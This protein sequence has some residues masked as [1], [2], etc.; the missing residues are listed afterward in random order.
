MLVLAST[1]LGLVVNYL[2]FLCVILSVNS[3]VVHFYVEGFCFVVGW[4]EMTPSRMRHSGQTGLQPT[5]PPEHAG[6][7]EYI[8]GS[9]GEAHPHRDMVVTRA[10]LLAAR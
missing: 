2:W 9:M 7:K 4:Q 3:E 5:T 10:R 1:N 8:G 6:S